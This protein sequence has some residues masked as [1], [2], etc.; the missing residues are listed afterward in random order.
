MAI[1]GCAFRYASA[2]TF[3]EALS[4]ASGNGAASNA[5]TTSGGGVRYLGASA[6]SGSARRKNNRIGNHRVR[7]EGIGRSLA[8]DC[9]QGFPLTY[10]RLRESHRA[11]PRISRAPA[12]LAD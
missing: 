7:I 9:T 12:A 10:H 6:V 8:A 4:N 11:D 2:I 1:D 5:A 3:F